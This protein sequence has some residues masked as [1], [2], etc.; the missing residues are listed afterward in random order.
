MYV[1]HVCASDFLG[2]FRA[3]LRRRG[4][5]QGGGGGGV[6]RREIWDRGSEGSSQGIKVPPTDTSAWS[7]EDV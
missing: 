5:G 3:H 7:A 4:G 1:H 2:G 6:E